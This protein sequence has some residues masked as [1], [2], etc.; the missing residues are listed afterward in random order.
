MKGLK[1]ELLGVH[2]HDHSDTIK[3]YASVLEFYT[4]NNISSH[5]VLEL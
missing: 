5:F 2:K 1:R 4:S 3:H